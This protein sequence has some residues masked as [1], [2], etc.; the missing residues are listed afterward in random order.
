MSYEN[1]TTAEIVQAWNSASEDL[2]GCSWHHR[3]AHRRIASVKAELTKRG[4][5]DRATCWDARG[6]AALRD[7]RLEID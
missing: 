1:M 6:P 5:F 4:F 3:G 7:S 2:K